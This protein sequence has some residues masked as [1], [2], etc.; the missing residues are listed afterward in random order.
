VS[1]F[2]LNFLIY[3]Y[4]C[5]RKA[6]QQALDYI[7]RMK[8]EVLQEREEVLQALAEKVRQEN[9]LYQLGSA[10][11]H[12]E[13]KR[14]REELTKARRNETQKSR[15]VAYLERQLTEAAKKIAFFAIDSQEDGN[16]FDYGNAN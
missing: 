6:E 3:Y 7:E 11:Q 5:H 14:L 9:E 16:D 15:E 1:S 4:Y 2:I 13:V 8:V 12:E 10:E